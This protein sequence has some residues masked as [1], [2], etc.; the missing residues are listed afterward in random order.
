[1][2]LSV[3]AVLIYSLIGAVFLVYLPYGV[4]GYARV[5]L[6]GQMSDR[7]EMFRRPRATV[8]LL[9]DYAQRA[10]WAHQN[11]FEALAVYG[12][13][14][15]SALVTGVDSP[16]AKIAAIAFLVARTLYPL[17]YILNIPVL[18]SMMFA[19]GNIANIT[20]F[21]LSAIAVQSL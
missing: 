13:A 20:L 7:L 8:D 17:F 19:V 5:K 11:A 3:S 6:A 18:R 9:P 12:V 21:A 1:M 10:N 14:C 2:N 15:L 16:W 4:V